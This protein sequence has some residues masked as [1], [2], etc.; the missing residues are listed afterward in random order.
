[1]KVNYGRDFTEQE[2]QQISGKKRTATRKEVKAWM[3]A[4]IAASLAGKRIVEERR[5]LLTRPSMNDTSL[6]TGK[7]CSPLD[8]IY[9]ARQLAPERGTPC[10]CGKRSWGTKE[11]TA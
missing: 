5:E 7:T 8:H 2:L 6:E 1:L 4:L 9:P 11:E 3:D 10:Y